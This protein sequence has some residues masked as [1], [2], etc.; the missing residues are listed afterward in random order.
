MVKKEI[1]MM[2]LEEKLENVA[3]IGR[4]NVFKQQKVQEK[5]EL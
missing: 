5:L 1:Q 4:A 3:R 2:K